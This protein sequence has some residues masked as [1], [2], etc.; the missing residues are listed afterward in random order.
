MV[1][2]E[3]G[4]LAGGAKRRQPVHAGLDQIVT[5]PAEHIGADLPRGVDG[6]DQIGKDAVEISH[7]WDQVS[8]RPRMARR[9]GTL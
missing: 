1:V 2:A 7:G 8:I 3:I 9:F 5:E 6:R 4:E